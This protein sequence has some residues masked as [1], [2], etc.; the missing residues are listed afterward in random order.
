[1]TFDKRHARAPPVKPRS[2]T[3]GDGHFVSIL[4]V[5]EALARKS[6]KNPEKTEE[7]A[8]FPVPCGVK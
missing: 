3:K 6:A 1:L 2:N 4:I 7:N 8:N 5:S